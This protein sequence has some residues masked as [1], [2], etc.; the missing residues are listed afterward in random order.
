VIADSIR[1]AREQ[2]AAHE[3]DELWRQ[4]FE[5]GWAAANTTVL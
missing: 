5:S 1:K 4:G 2:L 3:A